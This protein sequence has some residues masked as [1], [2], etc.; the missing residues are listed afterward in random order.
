MAGEATGYTV[1]P[2]GLDAHAGT[3]DEVAAAIAT[4]ADAIR[5]VTL[6]TSAFG[7]FCQAIPAMLRP[8]QDQ[9]GDAVRA[10]GQAVDGAAGGLRSNA[11]NYRSADDASAALLATA[12]GDD[13]TAG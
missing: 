4:A 10:S 12:G 7:V 9:I 5:T 6:D 3:L 1:D 13:G 11:S 8:L 2:G